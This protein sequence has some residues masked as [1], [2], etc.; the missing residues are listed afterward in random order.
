MAADKKFTKQGD[1]MN[2]RTASCYAAIMIIGLGQNDSN[3][4]YSAVKALRGLGESTLKMGLN[5]VSSSQLADEIELL[6]MEKDVLNLKPSNPSEYGEKAKRLQE[7]S[8][9]FRSQ[10]AG[11]ILIIPE[12][13]WKQTIAGE[14]KALPL[15]AMAEE[16]LGES[17]ILDN[18]KAAAEHYQSARLWWMQAGRQDMAQTASSFV[19]SYGRAAKCWFCGREVSGENIHFVTMSSD[20]TNLIR[21]SADESALPSYDQSGSGVYACKGCYGAIYKQA[22]SLALQRTK[23]L[24]VRIDTQLDEIRQQLSAIQSTL[25]QMN[26]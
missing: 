20:L 1:L 21:R 12:L 17:L 13:F 26:R 5:E 10:T 6:A 22:D 19:Q 2:A 23:E 11:K 14:S 24:E 8:M 4:L 9:R 3:S 15:A 25:R 16:A 18:P 7:L